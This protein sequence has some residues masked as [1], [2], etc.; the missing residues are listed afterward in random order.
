MTSAHRSEGKFA[1]SSANDLLVAVL[2][3]VGTIAVQLPFFDLWLSAMDEGHIALF[4]DIQRTGGALYR[5]ATFYPL[6]GAFLI[7]SFLFDLFGPSL[8]IGRVAVT[9]QFAAFVTV[10]YLTARRM[11]SVTAGLCAVFGLLLYRIWTFP[12]WLMFSYSTTALLFFVLAALV[13]LRFFDGRGA[14]WLYGS[15]LLYGVGVFCKQ[16][17]G[18]SALLSLGFALLV[19]VR[20]VPPHE[21]FSG[22]RLALGFL[23]PAAGVGALAGLWFLSQGTLGDAIQFTVLNHLLGIAS[24]DYSTVPSLFPLFRQDPALR[25]SPGISTYLPGVLYT[26]DARQ[27]FSSYLFRE[28]VVVDILV[29]AFFFGPYLFYTLGAVRLWRR[30]A[31]LGEATARVAVMTEL[32]V[33]SLGVSLLLLFTLNRPQDFVHLAVLYWPIPLLAS[34]YVAAA[35]RAR[36]RALRVTVALVLGAVL[37]PVSIYS[38][39]LPMNLRQMRSE[40]VDLERAGIK[41]TP[42]E[43]SVIEGVVEYITT[44]SEPEERIAVMPYFPVLHFLADRR[45]PHPAGYIVWPFAELPDR[46]QRIIDAMRLTDTNLLVYHFNYF[47]DFPRVAEYAPELFDYLVDNFRIERVFSHALFGLRMAVALREPARVGRP[48]IAG[49][50]EELPIHVVG[51]DAELKPPPDRYETWVREDRWPLRRVLALRPASGGRKTVLRV[52]VVPEE[53]DR[54]RSAVS[55]RPDA[56]ASFRPSWVSFSVTA[57]R[58]GRRTPLFH[59]R[60]DPHRQLEDRAWFEF[61]IDLADFAGAPVMLEF[62]TATQRPEGER[63]K[64]GGFEMPVLVSTLGG[65]AAVPRA[66]AR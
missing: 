23:G 56:W 35:L 32:V 30:R 12:H 3:F 8:W 1:T 22:P 4:A 62:A 38:A 58:G 51:A 46:D 52:P 2:V 41:M 40:S 48:L 26:A 47:L 37:V 27:F 50:F 53:G 16:D 18:G 11:T 66:A 57:V 64:M 7:L 31:Y 54:L 13:L 34:V 60:L 14:G 21:R 61:E 20:W 43:A 36:P 33:W 42:N 17:Y 19:F 49:S 44:H 28:T 9:L 39:Q 15:G 6:P 5:D 25:V 45:G 24:F 55:V 63:L 59:R 65:Q 29:K 10:L